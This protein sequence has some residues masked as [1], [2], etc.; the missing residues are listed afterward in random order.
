[1]SNPLPN[2][3]DDD[4]QLL[5]DDP[6]KLLDVGPVFGVHYKGLLAPVSELILYTADGIG[7]GLVARIAIA[8][9]FGIA[10]IKTSDPCAGGIHLC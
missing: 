8:Q 3:Y 4:T 6:Q 10:I 1:M 9:H 2:I 7:S 5:Y